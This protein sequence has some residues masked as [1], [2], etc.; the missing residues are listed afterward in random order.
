MEVKPDHKVKITP[1]SIPLDSPDY[2]IGSI[3]LEL[4]YFSGKKPR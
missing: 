2:R 3:Y 1:F 4:D